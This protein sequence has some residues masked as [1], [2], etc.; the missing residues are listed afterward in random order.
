MLANPDEPVQVRALKSFLFGLK[1]QLVAWGWDSKE[2]W[3]DTEMATL[4]VNN[5]PIAQGV[6]SGQTFRVNWC[7]EG[8]ANWQLLQDAVEM[9][10][11]LAKT[12]AK[13]EK[14]AGKG[15][16]KSKGKT[17]TKGE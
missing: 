9:K 1:K 14:G 7:D 8:W 4:K 6:V 11:L 15:G 2:V 5:V 10:D 17:Q 16:G 12:Q 13:L 3:V